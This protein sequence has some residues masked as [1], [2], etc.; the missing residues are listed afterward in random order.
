MKRASRFFNDAEKK[1]IEQAVADAESKTSAEIVP[2]LASASGR[3]DRAED[4]AGLWLGCIAM[5]VAWFVM[6]G[7]SA[8]V[9]D[10]GS[11]WSRLELPILIVAIVVGFIVG[12]VIAAFAPSV[13]AIFTPRK[14]MVEEVQAAAA[15]A[16]FD[17][18]IHH[19]EGATGV[20][21]YLSLFER[22]AVILADYAVLDKLEQSALDELCAELIE[23]MKAGDAAEALCKVIEHAGEKLGAVLPREDGDRDEHSNALVIM[24]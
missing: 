16:F 18:R 21:I 11:S 15:K 19:T 20:I 6:Q 7:Q 1:R 12:A 24:D 13:R 4:I 8:E 14:H 10:W 2:A 17:T 9:A 5:V 22:T 23:G 3:Y